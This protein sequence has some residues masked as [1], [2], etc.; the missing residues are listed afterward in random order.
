MRWVRTEG[1]DGNEINF[2]PSVNFQGTGRCTRIIRQMISTSGYCPSF[3][4]T[5]KTRLSSVHEY[6]SCFVPVY[7]KYYS[8]HFFWFSICLMLFQ[9]KTS[10]TKRDKFRRMSCLQDSNTLFQI[11]ATCSP[12]IPNCASSCPSLLGAVRLLLLSSL[13]HSGTST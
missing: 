2:N 1:G 9:L 12:V 3:T 4:T 13:G 8:L 11:L 10:S 6:F 5:V 7:D